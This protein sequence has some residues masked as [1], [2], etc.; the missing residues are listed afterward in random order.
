MRWL[1][2]LLF[3]L[4]VAFWQLMLPLHMLVG[5][6]VMTGHTTMEWH[7]DH[8]SDGWY[9]SLVR[10]HATALVDFYEAALM[11]WAPKAIGVFLALVVTIMGFVVMYLFMW[12]LAV[13]DWL[14]GRRT[15]S[16]AL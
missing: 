8:H 10:G 3:A 4:Y 13:G 14:D 11:P 1:Y 2:L 6:I 12:P 5:L 9:R 16:R 7:R 15:A